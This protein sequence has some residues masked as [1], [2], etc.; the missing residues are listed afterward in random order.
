MLFPMGRIA[1]LCRLRT[2]DTSK[3]NLKDVLT[4][5]KITK[6]RP[7]IVVS[8]SRFSNKGRFYAGIARTAFKTGALIIDSGIRTGIE[9]FTTRF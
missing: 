4:K 2:P 5:F 8:G 7:V 6:P 9:H 3:I 1:K